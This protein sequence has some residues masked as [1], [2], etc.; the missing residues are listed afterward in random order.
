ML[1]RSSSDCAGIVDKGIMPMIDALKKSDRQT[2]DDI[3]MRSVPPLS[4]A[5]GL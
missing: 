3:S 1:L 2:T 4:V 5:Q